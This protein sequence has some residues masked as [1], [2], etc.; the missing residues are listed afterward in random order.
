MTDH[1]PQIHPTRN[2]CTPSGEL[3]PVDVGMA[4]LVQTLWT[5]GYTTL[6]CCQDAGEAIR[7]GGTQIPPERWERYARFY[8]G[9][10]WLTM[11]VGDMQ[12]LVALTAD[13]AE[14]DGWAPNIRL[15]PT[16]PTAFASLHFPARQISEVIR[17]LDATQPGVSKG[18][19]ATGSDPDGR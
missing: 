2:L 5:T 6:M 3:V 19:H 15:R 16:G 8:D 12:R 14:G 4:D 17:R 11:P 1:P 9:F 18:R 10:A 7:G 13:L